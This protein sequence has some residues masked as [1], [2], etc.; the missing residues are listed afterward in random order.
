M[1]LINNTIKSLPGL[2]ALKPAS[3]TEISTAQ[4]QLRIEFSDEYSQYLSTFGAILADGIEL[5]GITKSPSRNV[6]TVTK[7]EW[8]LNPKVPQSLYVIE[9]L[10]IDGIIIWQ[11]KDGIVYQ[12]SPHSEPH[13]IAN[14][15]NDY[16]LEKTKS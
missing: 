10:G 9:N 1:S 5:T 4:I 3:Q 8:E 13:P 7:Q 14:S 6:S 11:D 16:I 12:S 15:L 2:L